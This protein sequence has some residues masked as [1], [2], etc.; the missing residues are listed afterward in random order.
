MN[1]LKSTFLRFLPALMLVIVL[2]PLA[3]GAEKLPS[4]AGRF[5]VSHGGRRIPVWY[6][7]PDNAGADARVLIAMHGVNR[8]ADRY[9]DEWLPHARKYGFLL[10]VPEFSK[11]SFPG[12]EQY[13]QG[14]TRDERGKPLP[15]DTWSFS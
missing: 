9:R 4:G 14:N 6:Y 2:V 1:S 12:E 10:L 7:L 13:N 5:E 15:R 3:V 8:D 11:E